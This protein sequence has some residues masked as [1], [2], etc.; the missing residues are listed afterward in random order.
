M[1]TQLTIFQIA[2]LGIFAVFAV[3][4]MIYF[5]RGTYGGDSG[6]IGEVLIWGTL[7]ARA[8][9][10]TLR[11]LADNDERLLSVQY[12]QYDPRTFYTEL[13]DAIASDKGP[14]LIIFEH[15]Y[16]HRDQ[17][18]MIPFPTE[19]VTERAFREQFIDGTDIFWTPEGALG[20]PIAVDPMV[21]YVNKNLLASAGFAQPPASW[22]EVFDIAEKA[23]KKDDAKTIVQSGIAFGEYENVTHAK[24]ILSTLMMQAGSPITMREADGRVRVAINTSVTDVTQP[25]Q[26]ALRYYTEFANPAKIVYSWNRSMPASRVAFGQGDVALY[27]GFASEYPIL[28]AQNPNLDFTA[29]MLPQVKIESRAVTFGRMYSFAVPRGSLNPNGALSAAL[30]LANTDA[31][32]VLSQ[33][34]GIPSARRDVLAEPTDGVSAVFRDSAII[35]RGW[36]DP[37]P[38]RSGLAFQ[39]MIEDA[40]SGSSRLSEAV[41]RAERELTALLNL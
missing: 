41:Q 14:D 22:N 28:R 21:L 5:A 34:T 19:S 29:A 24:E 10:A 15:E 8:F 11:A 35:A 20:V 4:G 13:S 16:I 37:D 40:T 23:T 38:M 39:G 30:I 32:R 18:K 9:S 3:G 6:Q 27:V 36:L 7:D 1:K 26:S 12:E 17:Q 2:I 25:A 31:S 33:A